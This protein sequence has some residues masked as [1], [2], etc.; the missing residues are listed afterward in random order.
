MTLEQSN[1]CW[2]EH[3]GED[4]FN[5]IIPTQTQFL[6]PRPQVCQ[7]FVP[8]SGSL[9]RRHAD[10][11]W[12]MPNQASE[13]RL[14]PFLSET[15]PLLLS[16]TFNELVKRGRGWSWMAL[17]LPLKADMMLIGYLSYLPL[18]A[19]FLAASLRAGQDRS[20]NWMALTLPSRQTRC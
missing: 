11:F 10:M 4:I 13:M 15:T 12:N 2:P 18:N 3:V 14:P 16:D 1:E 5:R 17:T 7:Q 8:V 20:W 6:R 9:R 19:S